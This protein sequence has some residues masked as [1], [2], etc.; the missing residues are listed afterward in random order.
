MNFEELF[1]PGVYLFD[2]ES[3]RDERGCLIE[4]YSRNNFQEH[5]I[6]ILLN[7]VLFVENGKLGTLRG[8]HFQEGAYAQG[9]LIFVLEGSIYEVIVDLRPDSITYRKWISTVLRARKNMIYIPK[10]CAHGYQTLE[11]GT[12]VIY[13]LDY[14]YNLEF[15]NGLRWDD[16]VLNIQ[17]PVEKKIISEKD[18]NWAYL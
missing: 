4:L 11:E 14:P 8:I 16:P 1:I 18:R 2:L 6:D 5:K 15:E 13:L 7:E 3:N 17:W 9:K 12:D 10:G